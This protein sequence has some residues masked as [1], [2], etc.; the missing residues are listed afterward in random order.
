MGLS[1]CRADGRTNEYPAVLYDYLPALCPHRVCDTAKLGSHCILRHLARPSWVR[2]QGKYAGSYAWKDSIAIPHYTIPH[3]TLH[4]HMHSCT[5]KGVFPRR[6]SLKPQL[7]SPT[8][9]VSSLP[10]PST[11]SLILTLI[12]LHPLISHHPRHPASS[13]IHPSHMSHTAILPY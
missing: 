13:P 7:A 11:Q 4:S 10:P 6:K 12:S 3:H 1:S 9:L 8:P 2:R 5:R